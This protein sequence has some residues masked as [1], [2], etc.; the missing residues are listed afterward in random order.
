MPDPSP[1]ENL[2]FAIL[3]YKGDMIPA[4]R[5][6]AA[7]K[8][9]GKD[10]ARPMPQ[11]LRGAPGG[12]NAAAEEEVWRRVRW[13]LERHGNDAAASMR[14]FAPI[15]QAGIDVSPLGDPRLDE[16]V[17]AV[18][19]GPSPAGAAPF[20]PSISPAPE[21]VPIPELRFVKKAEHA[22]GGLGLVWLAE[23]TELHRDV[24]LKEIKE[25][26]RPDDPDTQ[27]RFRREAEVTGRLEHPGIVPV[28]SLGRYPLT[29]RPFYAMRFIRGENLKDAIGRLHAPE[30]RR[31][32]GQQALELRRLLGRF[33]DA[34][35]AVAYAH[36]RGVLNRDIKPEN[37]MLGPFGETLV[38]DWGLAKLTGTEDEDE[39]PD[40]PLVLREGSDATPTKTGRA[41][42]TPQYMSPEQAAGRVNE[43]TPAS[44]VYSL[45]ATL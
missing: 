28:Y 31:E 25:T 15:A 8:A 27:K 3:A 24:A 30:A 1:G 40:G 5:L 19:Q 12:L 36:N 23:D 32:P 13:H 10:Q 39:L 41:V 33:L 26:A 2:L 4:S 17:R 14:D 11:I 29:G 35:N 18:I 38:V 43:L 34:C 20:P 44:D 9:W 37:V 16:A 6:I 21:A 22:A 7:L 42:G 45:G